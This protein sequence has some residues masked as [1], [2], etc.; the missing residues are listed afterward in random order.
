M[1]EGSMSG[2]AGDGGGFGSTGSTGSSTPMTSG[3]GGGGSSVSFLQGAIA[4]LVRNCDYFV[5]YFD[6]FTGLSVSLVIGQSDNFGS[7]FT[8]FNGKVL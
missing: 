6:W 2:G 7:G 3:G 1:G 8:T 5:Q 4:D